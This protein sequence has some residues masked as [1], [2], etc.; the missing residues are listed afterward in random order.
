MSRRSVSNIGPSPGDTIPPGPGERPS[1]SA[2]RSV[3]CDDGGVQVGQELVDIDAVDLG[4]DL[5]V[6]VTGRGAARTG[7]PVTAEDGDGLRV[8]RE[9]IFDLHLPIDP[10]PA[11]P[12]MTRSCPRAELLL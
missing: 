5:D 4:P 10:H 7:H 12:L 1:G 8:G 11:S 2:N 9:D 3:S 6:V